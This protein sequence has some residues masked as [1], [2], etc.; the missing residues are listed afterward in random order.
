MDFW[1]FHT[2]QSGCRFSIQNAELGS[3]TDKGTFSLGI[4]PWDLDENWEEYLEKIAKVAKENLSILAIG[5]CGFDRLKGP[6]IRLQKDAFCSQTQLA[7][8]LDIPIIL[9]CVKGHELLVEFLK[10]EKPIQKIIW[11]GWN[12]KPD[13]GRAL[14]EFPVYFS[15]GKH[16]LFPES[17]AQKWLKSVPINRVFLETDDA[18]IEISQIYQAASLILGLPLDQLDEQVRDNW[19]KISS[20]KIK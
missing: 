4:H 13:L 11:H 12:L 1:D 6:D 2:H 20:R 5:E 14:L 3:I 18:G 10:N 15:F 8:T 17:N 16:L 19:N 9:H 7:S